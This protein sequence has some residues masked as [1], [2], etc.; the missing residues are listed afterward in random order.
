MWQ[1]RVYVLYVAGRVGNLFIYTC[2]YCLATPP[3]YV[4][5]NGKLAGNPDRQDRFRTEKGKPL[6][7]LCNFCR[8]HPPP[9][10]VDRS[11]PGWPNYGGERSNHSGTQCTRRKYAIFKYKMTHLLYPK[12]TQEQ[13]DAINRKKQEAEAARG[14]AGTPG[15]GRRD[16]GRG[17][18]GD[19]RQNK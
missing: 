2:S 4:G 14:G 5:G 17:K 1:S 16:G 11:T 3:V 12:P 13:L 15:G 6:E 10:N 8:C 19:R 18:G 7:G 9:P